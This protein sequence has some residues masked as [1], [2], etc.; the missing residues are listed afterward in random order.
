MR[1]LHPWMVVE[2]RYSGATLRTMSHAVRTALSPRQSLASVSL[3]LWPRSV[4]RQVYTARGDGDGCGREVARRCAGGDGLGQCG[5]GTPTPTAGHGRVRSCEGNTCRGNLGS[6]ADACEPG[7]RGSPRRGPHLSLEGHSVGRRLAVH[8]RT[9]S[10]AR[11]A[12]AGVR[13]I[14]A[15]AQLRPP[16]AA[17][18]IS[19]ALPSRPRLGSH[20]R[21]GLGR[22]AART[23]GLFSNLG[24][25]RSPAASWLVVAVPRPRSS[26]LAR[27]NPPAL[28]GN[29]RTQRRARP[30]GVAP[31]GP[32]ARR[33]DPRLCSHRGSTS[34]PRVVPFGRRIAAHAARL[35]EP[36]RAQ[37]VRWHRTGRHDRQRP[38]R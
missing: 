25:R 19:P 6:R 13:V 27:G 11:P 4:F 15:G 37:P 3:L 22:G 35:R 26:A 7:M 31:E 33:M 38:R 17:T 14:R 9:S 30:W 16:P 5:R 32:L 24:F 29:T 1:C 18:R 36:A 10:T 20:H 28:R 12:P 23:V 2:G 21:V 8:P 34:A